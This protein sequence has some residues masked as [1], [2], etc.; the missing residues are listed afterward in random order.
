MAN[1]LL[2][3]SQITNEA[4]K[5]LE[6]E[7]VEYCRYVVDRSSDRKKWVLVKQTWGISQVIGEYETKK[8]AQAMRK[9]AEFCK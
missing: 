1:A 3:T 9:L 4:L 6:E 7:L 8:E 2:T 5:I